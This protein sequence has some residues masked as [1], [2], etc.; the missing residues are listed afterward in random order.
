MIA[1]RTTPSRSRLDSQKSVAFIFPCHTPVRQAQLS[2][3]APD[4]SRKTT[5]RE[6]KKME[7]KNIAVCPGQSVH[8]FCHQIFL[9]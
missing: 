6:G 3:F 1:R 2:I 4:L 5:T 7:G 8:L 9:P